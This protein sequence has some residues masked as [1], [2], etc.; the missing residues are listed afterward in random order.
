MFDVFK[1]FSMKLWWNF[2]Q[3]ESLWAKFMHSKY[4]PQLHVCHVELAPR[5]SFTWRR[6][7]EVQSLAESNIK[8]VLRNGRADFWHDNWI[9]DGLLCSK[10]DIYGEHIV[11]DFVIEGGWNIRMLEQ[12]L[13]EQWVQKILSIP[14]PCCVG[15]DTMVWAPSS[16][17]GFSLSSAYQV[18]R[19]WGGLSLLSSRGWHPPLPVKASFFMMQMLANKLPVMENLHRLGIYGPSKCFCCVAPALETVDHLFCLGD[20]AQQLWGYFGVDVGL[21]RVTGTVRH[22]VLEWWNRTS[23]NRFRSVM[24]KVVPAMICWHIWKARNLALFEGKQVSFH[25]VQQNVLSDITE[26]VAVTFP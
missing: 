10:V 19:T 8:W 24:F 9:G 12:W 17:G 4:S 25:L 26:G 14:P 16:S 23:R 21:V 3:K 13:P 5:C 6:L 22:R 18:A 7:V 20:L 1:A 15:E 11:R 2:R